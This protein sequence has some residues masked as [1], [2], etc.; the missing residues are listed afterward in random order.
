MLTEAV[1][2]EVLLVPPESVQYGPN[3]LRVGGTS[4]RGLRCLLAGGGVV[5]RTAFC[6]AV[7]GGEARQCAGTVRAA[8][9]RINRALGKLG[10]SRRVYADSERVWLTEPKCP[11]TSDRVLPTG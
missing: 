3:V 9:W 2:C 10:C 1:A 5:D 8:V 6:A 7:W 11:I 4:Y